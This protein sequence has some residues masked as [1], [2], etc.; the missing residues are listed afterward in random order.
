VVARAEPRQ[1]EKSW[2]LRALLVL[3]NPRPVFAALRD[4]SDEVAA[5]RQDTAGAIVWLA[6]IAAI[7]ATTVASTI[8]DDVVIDGSLF[9]VWAFLAGGLYGFVLYYVVGKL[10]HVSLRRLGGRGSFRRARH[11]LAF[12]AT[13]IALALLVYWPIRMAMYGSSLFRTGGADGRGAGPVVAWLFY[14]FVAWA[15]V[16]LVVGVRTVHGWTWAR[17]LAGVAFTAGVAAALAVGV[18]LLYALG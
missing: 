5:V 3:Q 13:P 1:D 18:G 10:L 8:R 9:A 16:L 4:D 6:G 2:F 17:S 14:G 15:L 12:A 7:L 11:L